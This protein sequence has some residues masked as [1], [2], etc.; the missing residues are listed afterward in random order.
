ML[1]I[2]AHI[3]FPDFAPDRDEVIARARAAGVEQM[4]VVGTDL[5]TSRAAIALSERYAFLYSS[6]GVH[7]HEFGESRGAS[8]E[9]RNEMRELREMARHPKVVA[10]GECGLDYFVRRE[11]PTDNGQQSVV[12]DEQKLIQKEGFLAQLEIARELGFPMIIHTRPSAGTMDAYE[13][14]F[15]VLSD[16]KIVNRDS[17]F[18][19]HCY[20]GDTGITR[21]FLSLPDV[22]FS[23]AGNV[24]YPVKKALSGT[25]DDILETVKLVPTERLFVETDCPYLAP[26]AHRGMRN[27]PAYVALTA[28]KVAETLGIGT[29]DLSRATAHSF[30]NIFPGARRESDM[31]V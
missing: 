17:K 25:K 3:Q 21:K 18:V 5:G 9:G 19:L 22:Y 11:Q 26:Q 20:Q 15:S 12:S 30:R 16:S 7:P 13:D 31:I 29:D 24:T 27:E 8:H 4:I 6:V 1:D 14:V 10:V 23:F 28:A 2:H